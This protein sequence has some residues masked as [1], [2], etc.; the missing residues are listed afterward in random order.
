[1][2]QRTLRP[3]ATL[4]TGL[5]TALPAT[6]AP[7]GLSDLDGEHHP[8]GAIRHLRGSAAGITTAKAVGLGPGSLG[9]PTPGCL[10]L[11][12]NMLR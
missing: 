10:R 9:L 8:A 1:M 4:T 11:G 3:A 7:S 2:R 12:Q 5:P 6:P